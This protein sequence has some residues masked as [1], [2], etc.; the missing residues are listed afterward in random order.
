MAADH[1]RAKTAGWEANHKRVYR[2]MR[3][4]NLYP[5][6]ARDMVLTGIDQLW[7]SEDNCGRWPHCERIGACTTG[8]RDLAEK[9]SPDHH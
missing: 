7:V 6:L 2:I 8:V 5:N 9:R 4:D 1:R 3:E